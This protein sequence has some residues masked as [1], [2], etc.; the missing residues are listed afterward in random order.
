MISFLIRFQNFFQSLRVWR[1]IM[2]CSSIASANANILESLNQ[3][4]LV[5]NLSWTESFSSIMFGKIFTKT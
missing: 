4:S 5:Q 2:I 3:C 1:A